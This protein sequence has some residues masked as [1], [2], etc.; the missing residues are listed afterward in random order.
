MER[1]LR[2]LGGSCR[3]RTRHPRA[4]KVA[5]FG[6]LGEG[7][8]VG[9]ARRS[10]AINSAAARGTDVEPSAFVRRLRTAAASGF[11]AGSCAWY[12]ATARSGSGTRRRRRCR[13]AS[14]S[15]TCGV[16]GSICGRWD[17]RRSERARPCA[18][19]GRANGE[20]RCPS[21]DAPTAKPPC[22]APDTSRPTASGCATRN[23]APWAWWVPA[24]S[25]AP[26]ARSSP[27]AS[28]AAACA[29][30]SPVPTPCGLA[31]LGPRPPAPRLPA[32]R[33][34]IP[35]LRPRKHRQAH[36]DH[37]R[38]Q[39]VQRI[40]EPEPRARATP[41][42]SAPAARRTATGTTPTASRRSP[43]PATTATPRRPPSGT[44]CAIAPTGS[45]PYPEGCNAPPAASSP[46]ATNWLHRVSLRGIRPVVRFFAS[47]SNSGLG[48]LGSSLSICPN[49]V[50]LCATAW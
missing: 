21:A 6:V 3:R 14:R 19:C 22:A 8:A 16:R 18:G 27:T 36:V 24:S 39:R 20:R 34:K 35:A 47:F 12:P 15:W 37:R 4:A 46:I 42:G 23:S 13:D 48:G 11:A 49:I 45:T 17:W 25:R 33:G 30:P 5:V 9:P 43:A 29:G 7:G 10:V 28:S 38:I 26:A 31:V 50:L 1:L 40:L 44:A 41:D 2:W 32:R